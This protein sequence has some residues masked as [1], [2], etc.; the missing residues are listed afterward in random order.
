[1]VTDGTKSRIERMLLKR[2]PGKKKSTIEAPIL[3]I[4]EKRM[5]YQNWRRLEVPSI[6][7]DL[8]RVSKFISKKFCMVAV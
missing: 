3:I 2:S 5:K 1:M 6:V 4:Q 7:N 8:L